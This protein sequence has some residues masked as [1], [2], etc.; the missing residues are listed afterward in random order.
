MHAVAVIDRYD[1]FEA[2]RREAQEVLEHRDR[3]S[4]VLRTSQE[5]VD[6]TRHLLDVLPVLLEHAD[7]TVGALE[8]DLSARAAHPPHA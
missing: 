2:L 1:D 3:G 5:M 7:P 8:G 4:G 6:V